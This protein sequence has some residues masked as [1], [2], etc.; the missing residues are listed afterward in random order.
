[1]RSQLA[2]SVL[3][4]ALLIPLQSKAE[5]T[6]VVGP[7]S[8]LFNPFGVAFSEQEEMYIAEYEGDRLWKFTKSKGLET[9]RRYSVQWN[10]QPVS[11][12]RWPHLY[13]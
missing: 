9:R 13:F 5:L 6:M 7:D 1:M 11:Y 2:Y 4:V 12:K 3:L 8:G 10:A